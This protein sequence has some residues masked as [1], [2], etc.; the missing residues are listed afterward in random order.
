MG[1]VDSSG[2][3]VVCIYPHGS[4]DNLPYVTMGSGSLAAMSVLEAGWKPDM[5]LA[6][7]KELMKKS[8][9]A[10]IFNDLMSGSHADIVVITREKVD[11]IRPFEVASKKGERQGSY[12]YQRGA[13]A[14]LSTRVIPFEIESTQVRPIESMEVA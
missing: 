7:A 10:G 5:E 2:G 4:S 1:G 9:C 13:S 8:I 11:F 12:R 6:E 14:V 3:H